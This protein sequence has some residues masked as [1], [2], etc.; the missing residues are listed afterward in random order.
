MIKKAVMA[1]ILALLFPYIITLAWTGKIEERKNVPI[2]TSGKKILLD[3][4]NGESYMDVEE[5]L[6]GVVAKQMPADYGREALRAQAVIAR[7][8]IY[9]KINGQNEVKESELHME[10]LEQQQ[11]EKLWGSE[12]FVAS[13]QA[14]EN[15]VRSTAKMVMM[16]DGKL[17]DPLF[18]RASTGKTRTGDENHPY[19]QPVSCPRDVEAEG[20]L[21]VTAYKKEDFAE[22]IN[23]ISGDVPVNADQI[24]G[25]I[26]IILREEGGYVGQIQIGTRVYTGE[27]IQRALGLPSSSYGFEEYEGGVRVICQGIGHGYGMSQYGAKCKAEEGWT[28]EQ[29]LPYFYKNIVLISE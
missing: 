2:V 27:E 1:C 16:Y 18:H 6:P 9:G 25:S 29:I 14:V 20:F 26:Q 23:Q 3:R 17:I 19:L 8:Y 28:A 12:A 7:T 10:Y 13:Y 11:M 24:P 22:K 4:K 5:Y 15:A 21:N